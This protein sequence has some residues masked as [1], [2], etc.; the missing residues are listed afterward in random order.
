MFN[1]QYD[2]SFM[3]NKSGYI[4]QNPILDAFPLSWQHSDYEEFRNKKE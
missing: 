2:I 3:C 1:P 4:I